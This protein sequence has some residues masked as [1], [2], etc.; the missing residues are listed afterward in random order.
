MNDGFGDLA[1]QVRADTTRFRQDIAAARADIRELGAALATPRR[2]FRDFARAVAADQKRIGET[3]RR[4]FDAL[5]RTMEGFAR[6]GR[7]SFRSLKR[8]AI[9]ILDEI[10]TR[11]LQVVLPDINPTTSGTIAGIILA[12]LGLPG[13]ANGGPITPNRPYLVGERGPEL[14]VPRSAG[15]VLPARRVGGAPGRDIR[16]TINV[17]A[18]MPED[19]ARA[20][21]TTIARAV[22]R[23]LVRSDGLA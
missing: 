3:G 9:G 19:E 1:G 7:L 22:R 15:E 18:P 11:A 23:A 17:L 13:R 10:A 16:I 12:G 8:V 14:V 20:S 21:A 2:Q 5:T 6:T 4:V